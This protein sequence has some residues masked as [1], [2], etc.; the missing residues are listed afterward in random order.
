MDLLQR[1][2]DE[3]LDYGVDNVVREID[4]TH[5]L[6]IRLG[7]AAETGRIDITVG[8]KTIEL[9]VAQPYMNKRRWTEGIPSLYEK[10]MFGAG[11]SAKHDLLEKT[12]DYFV[13]LLYYHDTHPLP[14][15]SVERL[16]RSA[17]EYAVIDFPVIQNPD[18]ELPP[19]I[20]GKVRIIGF[21]RKS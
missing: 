1:I 17:T 10:T 4:L 13:L 11:W 21:K 20:H 19:H 2:Y 12:P 16:L 9:K 15:G 3:I 18:H 7:G 6:A 8:G 5:D 14:P